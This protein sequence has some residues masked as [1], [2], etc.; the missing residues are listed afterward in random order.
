MWIVFS[1]PF[2][3]CL[4]DHILVWNSTCTVYGRLQHILP[5]RMFRWNCTCILLQYLLHKRK[6]WELHY[7]PLC[8][9]Q[10][11]ANHRQAAT[12]WNLATSPSACPAT[13]SAPWQKRS[14]K[15]INRLGL[16]EAQRYSTATISGHL[17]AIWP[18]QLH[19]QIKGDLKR[20]PESYPHKKQQHHHDGDD[21]DQWVQMKA[22]VCYSLTLIFEWHHVCQIVMYQRFNNIL[23]CNEVTLARELLVT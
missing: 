23:E 13:P 1:L 10:G 16:E 8:H 19:A 12:R 21:M 9:Q 11:S 5:I 4:Y 22:T 6:P 17:N 18:L 20:Q 14:C 3:R 2:A 15:G 7:L